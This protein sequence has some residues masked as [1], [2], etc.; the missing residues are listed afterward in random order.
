VAVC[1]LWSTANPAHENRLRELLSELAPGKSVSVSHEVAASVGEYARM[2]TT[3]VNA[4]LK[5]VTNSYATRLRSATEHLGLRAPLMLMTGTGGV[6]PAE[7]LAELPVAALLSGPV[8]GVVACQQLGRMMGRDRI[9]ATDIGGTSFDVGLVVDGSPLMAS[10]FSFGGVDVRV[11]CIDV[12]S[13]G[14]GGGS[15][16]AVAFGELTVGPQSAG[17]QP[18]PA[19]Y[20]RGGTAPTATDAD[21][22][23]G[24]LAPENLGSGISLDRQAAAQAISTHIAEPLGIGLEHAAWGIRQVLDNRMADLLRQVT[25]QR[26]HDPRGFTMFANGGCGPSHGWVLARELGIS[27][28]VVPAAATAQSAF[29]TAVCDIRVTSE[30]PVYLRLAAGGIPS[31]DE[32]EQLHTA[33]TEAVTE[34]T[35]VGFGE[36]EAGAVEVA[37]TVAIRYLGQS[38]HLSV[39]VTGGDITAQ[40]VLVCVERFEEEYERLYGR[41]A[42]FR[43][44]GFELLG[45]G[46]LVTRPLESEMHTATGGPLR[47]CGTRLV[48]FDDPAEPVQTDVFAVE[49]PAA[50]QRVTGPCLIT[51]PGQTA[52]VP[53]GS[54]AETDALG[55]LIVQLG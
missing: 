50:G 41:G 8:G 34:A 10:E 22:I 7:Y 6:M 18:G 49:F 28:F 40:S 19:C 36:L 27:E 39:P 13:I 26:G 16:A 11:P 4:A 12:R 14:A 33:V 38:H 5:P 17:A 45:A 21:L 1:T 32:V 2:S 43:G 15:I 48:W 51:Y 29:G 31:D 20:G 44:A 25:I 46:A 30:R 47:P 9:L 35:S 24:V 23:L 3:A 53:P 37:V 42:G 54:G 52:V 55:N